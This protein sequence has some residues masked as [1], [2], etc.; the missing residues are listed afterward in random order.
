MKTV[1]LIFVLVFALSTV[2]QTAP[3]HVEVWSNGDS[4]V[5]AIFG[6]QKV[7]GTSKSITFGAHCTD[8]GQGAITVKLTG[9]FFFLG[10]N[11]Q[12]VSLPVAD[13]RSL[14]I[15]HIDVVF[16]PLVAG[17]A[18]GTITITSASPLSFVRMKDQEPLSGTGK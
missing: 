15:T 18:T 8:N 1:A 9:P 7:G 11:S 16:R 13:A 6:E 17:V 3:C 14:A 12:S 2:A 10:L 5:G 4:Q